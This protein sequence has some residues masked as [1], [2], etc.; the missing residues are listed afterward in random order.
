MITEENIL[1]YI[2]A[3][4]ILYISVRYL[5]YYFY[6]MVRF[7]VIDSKL[8]YY[9]KNNISNK[10]FIA[11]INDIYCIHL[12]SSSEPPSEQ[13][14]VFTFLAD[15]PIYHKITYHTLYV[16]SDYKVLK[17]FPNHIFYKSTHKKLYRYVKK[18][19]ND[20]KINSYNSDSFFNF[21]SFYKKRNILPNIN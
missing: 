6:S 19:K 4:M 10:E 11:N 14:W 12:E 3:I 21:F 20:I 16:L 2:F 18:H 15:Y 5:Y 17:I 13:K 8:Y 7:V 1:W 9:M